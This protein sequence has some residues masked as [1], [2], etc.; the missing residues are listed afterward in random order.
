MNGSLID[1]FFCKLSTA[2]LEATTGILINQ[3]SDHLPY[4]LFLNLKSLVKEN[5]SKRI[6]IQDTTPDAI[7]KFCNEIGNS[8]CLLDICTDLHHDP[9]KNYEILERVISN[10]HKNVCPLNM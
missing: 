10:G 3:F 8:Q 4:F 1:N 7:A 9:N 6:K 5:V 2:S